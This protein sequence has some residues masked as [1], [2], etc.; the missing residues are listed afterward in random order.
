MSY[1][2]VNG[3]RHEYHD[4]ELAGWFSNLKEEFAG[5]IVELDSKLKVR[6]EHREDYLP[7]RKSMEDYFALLTKNL[8]DICHK[9]SSEVLDKDDIAEIKDRIKNFDLAL[10]EM[11]NFIGE[12]MYN[13]KLQYMLFKLKAL[14]L[15]IVNCLFD[16][17]LQYSRISGNGAFISMNTGPA[18]HTTPVYILPDRPQISLFFSEQIYNE[19]DKIEKNLPLC[20][21]N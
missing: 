12:E 4:D 5:F 2:C 20:S 17:D 21:L 11:K 6:V 8:E 14:L 16:R 1:T 13:G 15:G 7:K 10:S 19:I 3:I 18:T 9:K